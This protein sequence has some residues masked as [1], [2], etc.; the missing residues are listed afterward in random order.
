MKVL[1]SKVIELFKNAYL[2]TALFL[3][4]ARFI[5][6]FFV[7]AHFGKQQ[8]SIWANII[9]YSIIFTNSHL[10]I[11]NS[12]SI[13]MP[14][15][16]GKKRKNICHNLNGL[17]LNSFISSTIINCVVIFV[18]V[19]SNGDASINNFIS[20]GVYS[21]GF[22]LYT[23]D[24]QYYRAN[25]NF[26][27]LIIKQIVL[28]ISFI[29]L[30]A[31]LNNLVDIYTFIFY[32]G[33]VYIASNF[34]FLFKSGKQLMLPFNKH[35]KKY[36]F[37][38]L[39]DGFFIMIIGLTYSFLMNIDRFFIEHNFSAI[40]FGTYAFSCNFFTSGIIFLVI[41]ISQYYPNMAYKIGES[42]LSE[43]NKQYFKLE[44]KKILL[45]SCLASIPILLATIGVY[46]YP[47]QQLINLEN[48][49][50]IIVLT[51]SIPF[52]S[53]ALMDN[54][55]LTI[56]KL[57]MLQLQILIACCFIDFTF[58]WFLFKMG[59]PFWAQCFQTLAT[60][61]LYYFT[62]KYFLKKRFNF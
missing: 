36:F 47:N 59:L 16:L 60:S 43:A 22:T 27:V 10:G 26:K 33:L 24:F 45:F 23:Y 56:M 39:K 15:Y 12:Y 55:L 28:G 61:I 44:K 37:I 51:S 48:L 46:F 31:C 53:L 58:R 1:F 29:I 40:S 32:Y 54:S 9:L 7:L 14:F 5:T 3:Y 4:A 8:Y 62:T 34:S 50:I 41:I 19:S 20:V 2:S 52:F 30:F 35:I 18:V 11:L 42:G 57:Q 13:K 17:L 25:L 49:Y 38:S 6:D 21:L